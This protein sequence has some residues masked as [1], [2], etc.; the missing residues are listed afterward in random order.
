MSVEAEQ[1]IYQLQEGEKATEVM[2][3]TD[4]L[5]IWGQVI[6]KVAIRVS[7]WLRTPAIPQFMC[8]YEAHVLRF[9]S[10][11]ISKPQNYQEL[12][13]PSS[14]IIAFH[15]KPPERDPLDYDPNEPMRKMEPATALVGWF[16]F[17]GALRMSTQTNIARFLDVTKEPFIT[18]YDIEITQPSSPSGG[19]MRVPYAL[20]RGENVIF[21]PRA[22]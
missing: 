5:L 12:Y 10:G 18:M 9:G 20:V 16:H 8:I 14:Q 17:D 2:V 7:T 19:V 13:L 4:T 21:S 6:T 1:Q 11:G 22:N 3:Y 15:I